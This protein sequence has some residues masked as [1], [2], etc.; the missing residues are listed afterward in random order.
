MFRLQ[1]INNLRNALKQSRRKKDKEAIQASIDKLQSEQKILDKERRAY[2]SDLRK[3]GLGDV[4]KESLDDLW[5]AIETDRKRMFAEG[6]SK[7]E[8]REEITKK[9]FG[10]KYV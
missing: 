8:V 10:W 6:M 1:F 5:K 2:I 7:R 3:G 9:Y 4:D